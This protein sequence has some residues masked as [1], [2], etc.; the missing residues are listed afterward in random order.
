MGLVDRKLFVLGFFFST[1]NALQLFLGCCCLLRPEAVVDGRLNGERSRTKRLTFSFGISIYHTIFRIWCKF[2]GFFWCESMVA[3][4]FKKVSFGRYEFR[5]PMLGGKLSM[6]KLVGEGAV[7]S[8][9]TIP[10]NMFY[11]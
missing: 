7:S 4:V 9:L 3:R 8:R 10:L 11:K 6:G 5:T 2:H 1:I